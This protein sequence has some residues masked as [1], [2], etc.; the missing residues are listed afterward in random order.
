MS[1]F[2][3]GR[4]LVIVRTGPV[5]A[6]GGGGGVRMRGLGAYTQVLI[7]GQPSPLVSIDTIAPD[8]VE[9]IEVIREVR[10][11]ISARKQ[12]PVRSISS[13]RPRLVTAQRDAKFGLSRENGR[14]SENLKFVY[15]R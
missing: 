5:L 2:R 13:L 11:P 12:L 9:R 10:L 7:N 8:N 4:R 15:R 1:V 14:W 3:V 6:G